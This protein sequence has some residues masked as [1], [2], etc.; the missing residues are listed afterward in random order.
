M[1]NLITFPVVPCPIF[2]G[3][4]PSW[5]IRF[6]CTCDMIVDELGNH[7]E[8]W[9][10]PIGIVPHC[11][12]YLG[13]WHLS[14]QWC[15]STHTGSFSGWYSLSTR[16]LIKVKINSFVSSL[17]ID[18]HSCCNSGKATLRPTP[19]KF[20]KHLLSPSEHFMIPWPY[21]SIFFC[22]S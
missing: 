16:L 19:L 15:T 12:P 20:F 21:L 22:R 8:E 1:L 13:I 17:I 18:K 2:W 7:D 3:L 14:T 11:L 6:L 4:V 10:P 9:S 5:I